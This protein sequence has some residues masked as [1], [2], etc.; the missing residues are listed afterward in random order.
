MPK[1]SLADFGR[2]TLIFAIATQILLFNKS[3]ILNPMIKFA[4][5]PGRFEATST[6]GFWLSGAFQVATFL[7]LALL[8]PI[9]E[10]IFRLEPHDLLIA[11]AIPLVFWVRDWGFCVQQT[12]Y[13]TQRLFWIEA[14]YW[15]GTALGFVW[16]KLYGA[17]SVG[18]VFLI[19]FGCAV[20]SSLYAV[21]VWPK[22]IS[23][24]LK[25]DI[26]TLKQLLH[27]GLYTVGLGLSASLLAGA[28]LIVLGAIYN[29]EI[30]G[31]YGGAKRV[32]SVVAA[33]VSTVGL[34]VIP[35]ASKLAA[36]N[37]MAEVRSLFEKTVAYM[38]AGMTVA[39]G[40]GWLLAA[41]FYHYIMPSTYGNSV[42]LFRLLLLAAPFEALF[43]ITAAILYGIGAASVTV[44]TSSL[45]LGLL[46]V[47]LPA[48]AY[49]FGATGA[50][51][52]QVVVTA[53]AGIM[54]TW[55]AGQKVNAEFGTTF[56]RLSAGLDAALRKL[57]RK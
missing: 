19:V 42:P 7:L 57:G 45:A 32:Y 33:L 48:S 34:L 9:G 56:G 18:E 15:V 29:A 43:Y 53:F 46:V 13:Q 20:L 54:M 52:S 41:P 25:L 31:I 51:L 49:F 24:A 47:V 3:L 21:V 17:G 4:A 1:L 23:L 14:V 44:V 16:F 2:Y 8:A 10:R 55:R 22:G 30:V 50:A 39:V 6:V 37:R 11:G 12:A 28:D 26:A 38:A 27:Y 36:E 40:V 5:E 35:Y